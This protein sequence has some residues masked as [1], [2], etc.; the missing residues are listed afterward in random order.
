ML[1]KGLPINRPLKEN[2]ILNQTV[3]SLEISNSTLHYIVQEN[4]R[5]NIGDWISKAVWK[6]IVSF[7]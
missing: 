5:T 2:V 7:E 1:K 4:L 3:A 6:K